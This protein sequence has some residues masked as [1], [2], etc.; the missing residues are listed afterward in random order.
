MLLQVLYKDFEGRLDGESIKRIIK[1]FVQPRQLVRVLLLLL[2]IL[3]DVIKLADNFVERAIYF[4]ERTIV[5]HSC[6]DVIL[7]LASI[8]MIVLLLSTSSR[9]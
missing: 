7:N 5:T 3:I 1:N 2:L 4:V 8:I 9:L 6:A